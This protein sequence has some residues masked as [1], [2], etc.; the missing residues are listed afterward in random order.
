MESGS[1]FPRWQGEGALM[2]GTAPGRPSKPS[3]GKALSFPVVKS[4]TRTFEINNT[5]F[6]T[7]ERKKKKWK[8][9]SG[10][11][12]TANSLLLSFPSVCWAGHHYLYSRS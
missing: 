5:S 9:I 6:K 3:Q 8:K 1:P 7:T 11:S 12:R 2:R 4:E 10:A